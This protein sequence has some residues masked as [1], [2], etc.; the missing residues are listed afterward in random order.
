MTTEVTVSTLLDAELKLN[1]VK[2]E[3]NVEEA[4]ALLDIITSTIAEV[5]VIID[6]YT[7]TD[8]SKPASVL[9]AMSFKQDCLMRAQGL[10]FI[11]EG[12]A[13]PGLVPGAPLLPPNP[14]VA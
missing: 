7:G 14:A 4:Q 1:E 10:R 3:L 8:Q 13:T 2:Q 6:K 5:D 9:Q 12:P 11:I